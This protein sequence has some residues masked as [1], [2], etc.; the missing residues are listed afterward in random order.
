M[1]DEL[2]K[3]IAQAAHLKATGLSWEA[4]AKEVGRNAETCRHWP[5]RYPEEWDRFF[6]FADEALTTEG[7][8]EARFY[9]RKLLRSDNPKYCHAAAQSLMRYRIEQM[10]AQ[11]KARHVAKEEEEDEETS[12]A[13]RILKFA[14]QMSTEEIHQLLDRHYEQRHAEREGLKQSGGE[15]QSNGEKQ[16]SEPSLSNADGKGD[17]PERA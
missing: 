16:S 17:T 8:S 1:N 4:V 11:T 3:L 6:R 10:R 14:K 9:M 15:K 7:A 13:V 12:E 5:I 2:M